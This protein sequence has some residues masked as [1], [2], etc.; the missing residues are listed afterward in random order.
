[1]H[2]A[3]SHHNEGKNIFA[4]SLE[5]GNSKR[6]VLKRGALNPIRGGTTQPINTP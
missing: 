5:M 1:M 2:K 6:H 3:S 4:L